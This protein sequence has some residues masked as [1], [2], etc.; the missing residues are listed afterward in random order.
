MRVVACAVLFAGLA[1]TGIARAQGSAESSSRPIAQTRAQSA[2]S[3]AGSLHQDKYD[4]PHFGFSYKVPF[5]WVDRTS[6]MQDND[7]DAGHPA[8]DPAKAQVL[9]GVFER[10][11][12]AIGES[13]NSTVVIAAES[14]SFY[15]GLKTAVNYF[16]PLEEVVTAKGFKVVNQPY[17]F[18][19]GG[20]QLAREDFSQERGKLTLHQ[21]TLVVLS[22]GYVLSFTYIAGSDDEVDELI[23]GLS[24][25]SVSRPTGSHS[26]TPPA[27]S[28]K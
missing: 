3:I 8:T 6:E 2:A 14:I 19:V 5:G 28:K 10:P 7:S 27:A 1:S 22:K 21:S 16:D 15:P 26:Q 11:P 20:K 4:N 9:L 18:P 17:E 12:V 25:S 24:F 23:E 13:I